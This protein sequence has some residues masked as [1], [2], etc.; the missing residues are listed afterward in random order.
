MSGPSAAHLEVLVPA[1]AG[2]FRGRLF[3]GVLVLILSVVPLGLIVMLGLELVEPKP[4]NSAEMFLGVSCAVMAFFAVRH[5]VWLVR[6]GLGAERR[7]EGKILGLFEQPGSRVTTF[8]IKVDAGVFRVPQS[9]SERLRVGQQV[10]A[11]VGRF[12]GDLI[13]LSVSGAK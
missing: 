10:S 1:S 5:G 3:A 9:V 7:V 13:S 6:E 2:Y 4:L 11:R 8:W 12:H